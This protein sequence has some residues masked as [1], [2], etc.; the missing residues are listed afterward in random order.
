MF[1]GN[2]FS[3]V[4]SASV[5]EACCR[6]HFENNFFSFYS[7][8]TKSSTGFPNLPSAMRFIPHSDEIPPLVFT[9]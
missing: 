4:K 6:K 5:D 1:N 9:G 7:F 3:V 8:K 2:H